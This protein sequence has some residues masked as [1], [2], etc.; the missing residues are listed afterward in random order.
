VGLEQHQLVY[1]VSLNFRKHEPP[2]TGKD[3][4]VG[5]LDDLLTMSFGLWDKTSHFIEVEVQEVLR[6][7]EICED[8]VGA[9]ERA[10]KVF[11]E[12]HI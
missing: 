10:R 12:E 7:H 4:A 11:Q 6:G 3:L 9:Y 8:I 5:Y 2:L 1:T